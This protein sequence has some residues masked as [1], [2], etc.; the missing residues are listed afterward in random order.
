MARQGARL[1]EGAALA[2]KT[3]DAIVKCWFPGGVLLGHNGVRLGVL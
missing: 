1:V 3:L 2:E